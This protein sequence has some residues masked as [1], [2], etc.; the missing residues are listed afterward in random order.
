MSLI[1]WMRP[2]LRGVISPPRRSSDRCAMCSARS[3]LRS[4]SGTIC[5]TATRF[6]SSSGSSMAVERR[7]LIRPTS[8]S[9]RSSIPAAPSMTARARSS[10]WSRR[11]TVAHPIDSVTSA[12][13]TITASSMCRR[14]SSR[15]SRTDISGRV[16][17]AGSELQLDGV[18]VSE[19]ALEHL[20]RRVAGE[21]IDERDRLRHLELRQLALAVRDQLVLG[22]D[23]AGLPRYEGD[24][25]LT[26]AIIRTGDHRRLQDRMVLV[27]HPL[28]L[29][30]GD[31]LSAGHDH[32]LEPI[33]D[34]QVA[35]LVAH[36]DVA[37]VEPASGEGGGGRGLVAP[38]A[39][40]HLRPPH[41]DL[42]PL[43]GGD[44][45]A[46]VVPDVE[47]EVEARP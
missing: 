26:P 1:D 34:E 30:A 20:P 42:A 32:V 23:R 8:S 44:R 40:E 41:D 6:S 38:V 14:N 16:L 5:N 28:D 24:R 33:D 18:V 7:S 45:T 19:L 35:V 17:R 10:S 12:N 25:H 43:A 9:Q 39:L 21:C 13:S 4:S 36:A 27:Q 31:V 37:G 3:A 46:L 2:R 29:G 15:V 22:R 11:A 47:L